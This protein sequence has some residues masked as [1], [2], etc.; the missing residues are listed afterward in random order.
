MDQ[1]RLVNEELNEGLRFV[2]RFHE[3]HPVSVAFWLKSPD[4]SPWY[5]YIV[6]ESLRGD[7][8][9]SA[10]QV[11]AELGVE[12]YSPNFDP[13]TIKLIPSDDPLAEAAREEIRDWRFGH[14]RRLTATWFG[15]R[16]VEGVYIYPPA[17]F[18][19]VA[20]GSPTP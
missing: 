10:Y 4:D 9:Y 7:D 19:A 5:L 2:R 3:S 20:D 8:L 14:A 16:Y 15:D 1:T 12:S 11:V 18:A 6:P 13:F 17:E